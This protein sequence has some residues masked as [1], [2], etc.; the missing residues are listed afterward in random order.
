MRACV[1]IDGFVR[2]THWEGSPASFATQWLD[3]RHRKGPLR[4]SSIEELAERRQ[5]ANPRVG[6]PWCRYLAEI[7]SAPIAEEPG[8]RRWTLDPMTFPPSPHGWTASLSFDVLRQVQVPLLALKAAIAEPMAGQPATEALRVALPPSAEYV[9]L[10]GL[11]H[12]AHIEDPELVAKLTLSF[13]AR[14]GIAPT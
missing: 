8:K 12:F 10:E 5:K 6:M 3:L 13:L 4:A 1:A 7:G 11:G 2:R 9:V 14:H